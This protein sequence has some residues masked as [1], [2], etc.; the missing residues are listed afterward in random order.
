[1][2]SMPLFRRTYLMDRP[3]AVDVISLVAH[4]RPDSVDGV[5][6]LYGEKSTPTIG[7]PAEGTVNGENDT[8]GQAFHH[9]E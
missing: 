9:C 1:M 8:E 4:H 2:M 7:C 6:I 5:P 3:A